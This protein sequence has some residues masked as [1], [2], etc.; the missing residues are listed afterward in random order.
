MQV[1]AYIQ[2]SSSRDIKPKYCLY[3][4]TSF[5]AKR[6]RK[7]K[8]KDL[9]KEVGEPIPPSAGQNV[10]R[11]ITVPSTTDVSVLNCSIIKHEYR[12]KV[13]ISMLLTNFFIWFP[14]INLSLSLQ[15]T[16]VLH[17]GRFCTALLTSHA[18]SGV[19]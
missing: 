17:W 8:T 15:S 5:F 10:I 16:G 1:T 7:V 18:N 2:N 3:I 9:V 13:C 14:L 4:K 11:V 12:L 6:K 19:K